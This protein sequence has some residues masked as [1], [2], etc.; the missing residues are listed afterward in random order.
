MRTT[1]TLDDDVASAVT[2]LKRKRGLG[3]SEA[4]NQLVRRGLIVRPPERPFRQR[5]ARLALK[6]YVTNVAEA[7][8]LLDGPGSS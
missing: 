8:E 4:V 2:E 7:I 6:V 5:T 3:V 1:V